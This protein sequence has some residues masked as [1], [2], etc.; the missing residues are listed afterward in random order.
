MF[1]CLTYCDRLTSLHIKDGRRNLWCVTY[2]YYTIAFKVL[3]PSM[4]KPLN[5]VKMK[6]QWSIIPAQNEEDGFVNGK[7]FKTVFA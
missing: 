3:L 6:L 2:W 5:G 7:G 1:H 4:Q